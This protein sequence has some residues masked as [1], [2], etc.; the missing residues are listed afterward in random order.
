[1]TSASVRSRNASAPIRRVWRRPLTHRTPVDWRAVTGRS[2]PDHLPPGPDL[3][4]ARPAVRIRPTGM[5]Q[6]V[7]LQPAESAHTTAG[8]TKGGHTKGGHTKGGHTTAEY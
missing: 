5:A 2:P 4:A 8:H 1:M 7:S 3:L 6:G